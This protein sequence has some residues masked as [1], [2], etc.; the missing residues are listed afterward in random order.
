[1]GTAVTKVEKLS[2]NTNVTADD[3]LLEVQ[4]ELEGVKWLTDQGVTEEMIFGECEEPWY[5]SLKRELEGE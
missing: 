4:C 2:A 5:V 1:M 3:F